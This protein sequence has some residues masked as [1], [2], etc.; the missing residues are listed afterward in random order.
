MHDMKRDRRTLTEQPLS[1]EQRRAAAWLALVI[2]GVTIVAYWGVFD[3]QFVNFDDDHY[4]YLN[5]VIQGGFSWS[6]LKWAFVAMEFYNWH[7]LTWISLELDYTLYGLD[8]RGYHATSLL[9]HVANSVLLL[10][11]LARMTGNVA[12][13]ACVAAFFALHPMHVESVAWISERKDVLSGFFWLATTATYVAYC[14]RPGWL[15]YGATLVTFA[16]GLMAKPMLVTLPFVMLLMDCWPLKRFG[17]A[18]A[19]NVS[20]GKNRPRVELPQAQRCSLAWLLVEKIPFLLLSA[21]SCAI[22]YRAQQ[23]SGGIRAGDQYPLADRLLNVPLN[24]VTYL[25]R[26]FWPTNLA[27][28][29]PYANESPP[30][31]QVATAATVLVALTLI[32]IGFARRLP[33]LSVGWVWFVGTLVPVIGLVQ[34]GLQATADRY[35]YMPMIGLLVAVCWAVSDLARRMRW[36]RTLVT[37]AAGLVL[38]ACAAATPVQVGYWHDGL[39]LWNRAVRVSPRSPT[40]LSHLAVA[41]AERGSTACSDAHLNLGLILLQ[42]GRKQQ[43][44]EHLRS[45]LGD[46][47]DLENLGL[48]AELEGDSNKAIGLYRQALEQNPENAAAHELLGAALMKRGSNQEGQ[49]HLE[50]AQRLMPLWKSSHAGSF[51]MKDEG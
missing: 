26:S 7:P 22:S 11:L 20:T 6:F 21:A 30:V 23:W 47:P 46:K 1:G 45:A 31:W 10:G 51:L 49:R 3:S 29:Y 5:H 8:P 37:A 38:A 41:L 27:V 33:Y 42:S 39:T 2:A 14:R 13:S 18:E 24:Y 19:E 43:A 34:V 15:G 17:V 25:R 28:I 16:L 40:A 32:S 4:V 44:I 12:R 50:E 36:P 9:L 48:L 35:T